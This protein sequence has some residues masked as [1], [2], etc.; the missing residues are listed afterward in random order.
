MT[1]VIALFVIIMCAN[2]H[3]GGAGEGAIVSLEFISNGKV[4][5][6]HSGSRT[7]VPAC[8]GSNFH[9]RW[10]LDATTEGGKVQLAGL[11]MAYA[12]GKNI[13]IRGKGDCSAWGDTEAISNFWT[14][15]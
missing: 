15:Y 10:A 7:D 12:A 5:F 2:A 11:L 3:A 14:A 9:S 1:K 6:R 8:V 4:L 13:S